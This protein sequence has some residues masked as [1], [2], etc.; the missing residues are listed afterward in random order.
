MIHKRI[1]DA[2]EYYLN[3]K[4]NVD[5]ISREKYNTI[6]NNLNANITSQTMVSDIYNLVIS[7][8]LN[9]ELNNKDIKE[10]Q[11][12]IKQIMKDM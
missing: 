11:T 5:S 10:I 1:N 9:N 12:E 2:L 4:T 8:Y 7:L 6:Q 3:I